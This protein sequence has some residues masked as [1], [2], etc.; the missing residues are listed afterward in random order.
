L[1][2]YDVPYS[3]LAS[4][5]A[6]RNFIDVTSPGA[7]N[8]VP[9]G[10]TGIDA[11]RK[12]L[13]DGRMRPMVERLRSLFPVTITPKRIAGIQTDVVEPAS[14]V[15]QNNRKRVLINVHGGGFS[16]A[17]RYGGQQES[18][19]IASV[20]G[21]KIVTVDYRMGP[22]HTFP[23]ASEDVAAVYKALLADHRPEE[24]GIYGC[25]A[26]G[27]LAA[28]AAA[29]LQRQGLPRPGAIGIFGAGGLV[30]KAGDGGITTFFDRHLARAR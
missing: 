5:G 27:I 8:P 7:R 9:A 22:E 18:I 6:K 17:A 13:D 16:A 30:G 14:G 11:M 15:S 28:Q 23:A 19:P 26:G 25:S 24:I 20:G 12:A 1:P 21:F 29:W 2:A 4:E 10:T 3:A